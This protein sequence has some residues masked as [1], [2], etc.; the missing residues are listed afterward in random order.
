VQPIRRLIVVGPTP[1]NV[2]ALAE[3]LRADP[4]T[5]KAD[6]VTGLTADA[7]VA[8]GDMITTVTRFTVPLFD[9]RHVRPGTHID[10]GGAM[11]RHKREMDDAAA[12]RATFY[13]DCEAIAWERAGDLVMPLERGVVSSDRVA[14]EIGNVILGRIAGRANDA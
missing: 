7:A 3:R 5:G 12:G 11:R 14:G 4:L 6:V 8:E 1:A 13:L 9:G 2:D 10:L